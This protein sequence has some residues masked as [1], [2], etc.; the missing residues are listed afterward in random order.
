MEVAYYI[1]EGLGRTSGLPLLWKWTVIRSEDTRLVI[2][3]WL[4]PM[5]RRTL[6]RRSTSGHNILQQLQREI[7]QT[8]DLFNTE[9]FGK[10]NLDAL[11]QTCTAGARILPPGAPS[12]SGRTD[13]KAFWAN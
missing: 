6:E 13:I 10:R 2:S 12:I 8:N 9:V 4:E 1:V 5:A 11:D 3:G 7:A